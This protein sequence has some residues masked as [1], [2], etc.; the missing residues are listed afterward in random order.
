MPK[1][2]IDLEK[3]LDAFALE[4]SNPAFRLFMS[5]DPATSI[6]IGLLEKSIKL[7][8]EPP[9]GV[10]LNIKKAFTFFSKEDIEDKDP[11]VKTILFALCFFHTVM[12]E[13]RKFGPKGWNM[14]YPFNMGDLRD[15]AVVLNNYMENNASSGKIPWDD[16]KYLFGEIMY[17]GHIVDNWDRILCA[18]YLDSIMND[19]LLDEAELFPFI[20][21]KP[22]SFKCPTA[23]PYEKYIEYIETECP[24]ETPLAF[25]MHPNAEIDF[26]TMQCI[27]LFRTLQEIQPKDAGAGGGGGVTIQDKIQEFMV[28]VNDEASLDSNKLNIEDI[29]SKLGEE[30]RTPYQNAFL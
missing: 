26:R 12:L 18:A 19:Q 30:S 20:E 9:Q 2:L 5:S 4:G 3:K 13:R 6:P 16:L 28:R 24:P 27:E 21:G 15:S 25:G 23:M 7:T 14:K 11:K 10:K 29:A 17:G 1:F 22:I 8:N